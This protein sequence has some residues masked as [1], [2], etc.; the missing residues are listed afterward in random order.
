MGAEL[1]ITTGEGVDTFDIQED[2][3]TLPGL[4]PAAA[5]NT[6]PIVTIN[7]VT[8]VEGD[9][10]LFDSNQGVFAFGGFGQAEE[11]VTGNFNPNTDQFPDL[12]SV[13][14]FAVASLASSLASSVAVASVAVAASSVAAVAMHPMRMTNLQGSTASQV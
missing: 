10:G 9:G 3:Y 11:F 5:V 8:A 13:A 14:S 7:D 2:N 1:T 12:V 4:P 6:L